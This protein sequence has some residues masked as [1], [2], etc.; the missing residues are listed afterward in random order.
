MN[1][2]QL[3][4]Q[5]LLRYKKRRA[6]Q[7]FYKGLL[8]CAT[9]ILSTL[10][11]CLYLESQLYLPSI[12]RALLY[13]SFISIA[14]LSAYVWVGV[15]AWKWW[16]VH[17]RLSDEQTARELS[18]QLPT[19]RDTLIHYLQLRKSVAHS[20]LAEAAY[21]TKAQH[22]VPFRFHSVLPWR[23]L[24]KHAYYVATL[25]LL[26]LSLWMFWPSFLEHTSQRL[27]YYERS[28]VPPSPFTFHLQQ[29]QKLTALLNEEVK[30][31]LRLKGKK[32]PKKV[33]IVHN[34]RRIR[35][36]RHSSTAY[37][38]RFDKLQRSTSFFFEANGFQS[39][40]Y[41]IRVLFPPLLEEVAL[42]LQYP[43]YMRRG[44]DTLSVLSDLLVPVGTKIRWHIRAQATEDIL[45]Y[46]PKDTLAMHYQD[47]YFSTSYTFM[48]SA[49]YQL[50]LRN[51]Q[52]SAP[53]ALDYRID[54][55]PD[56][57]PLLQPSMFVDTMFYRFVAFEGYAI[58]DYGVRR[59]DIEYKIGSRTSRH[60]IPVQAGKRVVFKYL[61]SLDSL[62][63]TQALSY[64]LRAWDNDAIQGSK[65]TNTPWYTLHFPKETQTK[66][67]ISKNL[68]H[69]QQ[70]LSK[71][72]EAQT[73]VQQKLEKLQ[74]KLKL[75]TSLSWEE[76]KEL[77][78]LLK[79]QKDQQKAI[80]QLQQEYKALKEYMKHLKNTSKDTEEKMS[81]IE[82][83]I[84]SLR[85]ERSEELYHLLQ[86]LMEKDGQLPRFQE[87]LEKIENKEAVRKQNLERIDKLLQRLRTLLK[88][89]ELVEALQNLRKQQQTLQEKTQR[90]SNLESLIE[91][92]QQLQ[93]DFREL[94]K[95]IA[96]LQQAHESQPQLVPFPSLNSERNE[97]RTMQERSTMH[98]QQKQKQQAE[99]AQQKAQQAIK[100]MEKHLQAF[101]TS[102]T[103][104]ALRIDKK[105][106]HKLLDNLIILSKEQE[107]LEKAMQDEQANHYLYQDSI[108]RHQYALQQ[109][110]AATLDSLRSFTS[111]NF[112]IH[113]Q[114][115][116]ELQTLKTA[117]QKCLFYL[118]ERLVKEAQAKQR[119]SMV[120]LNRLALYLADLLDHLIE[121]VNPSTGHGE[122]DMPSLSEQQKQLQ[123]ALRELKKGKQGS[124]SEF[125]EKLMSIIMQQEALRERVK[126]MLKSKEGLLFERK[127]AE[128]LQK[129][130]LEIEQQLAYKRVS[131][132]LLER[133]ESLK[134]R[135]L[136]FEQANREHETD[137]QRQGEHNKDT[138]TQSISLL[139]LPS[140][141]PPVS[142]HILLKR[143][144][145]PLKPYYEQEV[146]K[147][148]KRMI[149]NTEP[150]ETTQ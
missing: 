67:T 92:Q 126:E 73:Q 121:D 48:S 43:R 119:L 143:A 78:E 22:L 23:R 132:E 27:Y 5:K 46:L 146:R 76:K 14:L 45:L 59:I 3:I 37:S 109:D 6:L 150:E 149:Q 4:E 139:K 90:A 25:L 35:M 96:A 87:V 83:A 116:E 28:F 41:T 88:R 106:L 69:Q 115:Y 2:H 136:E 30:L 98:L 70:S 21:Q 120:S 53:Q 125:S 64:R 62:Q 137:S 55:A 148:F 33:Y 110:A 50:D 118:R 52:L 147:Y 51:A 20:T 141:A 31:D 101:S 66:E 95:K 140:V 100:K 128:Q 40:T 77:L 82:Q 61:W 84:E 11:L 114:V 29:P 117:M 39:T 16:T 54:V 60:A 144:P 105:H 72:Q 19:L 89:K 75:K 65:S 8:L 1:T 112:E 134:V 9:T 104:Q 133:Q 7:H 130:M 57:H 129:D 13:F 49:S 81:H 38:Y 79:T 145:L 108:G 44:T 123:D 113:Q 142:E 124:D 36:Q 99:E 131:E 127:S 18:Q 135:L 32:Y 91:E 94:E 34:G 10:L 97:V 63:D 103:K 138:Y 111:Q 86:E 17:R 15:R 74:E 80:Q 102:E 56:Q 85:D 58:D 26:F 107:V 47:P 24:R 93:K 71:Q 122:E 68:A 12:G 42:S